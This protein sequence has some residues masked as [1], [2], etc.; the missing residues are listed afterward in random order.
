MGRTLLEAIVEN[1]VVQTKRKKNKIA[2]LSKV[3]LLCCLNGLVT[4]HRLSRIQKLR[5]SIYLDHIDPK[6]MGR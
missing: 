1:K 4:I 3:L 2:Y 6:G 5:S